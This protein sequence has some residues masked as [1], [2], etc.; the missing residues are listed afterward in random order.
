MDA[1]GRTVKSMDPEKQSDVMSEETAGELTEAMKDV[2]NE[3][4]G[5]A[6][7]LSGWTWPARPAPPRSPTW[8]VVTACRTRAWFV[9]FAPADDP[10]IAVAATVRSPTARA[11][12]SPP[13]LLQGVMET[14]L[15]E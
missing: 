9:G 6:A 8:T 10:Q 5:T 15:G 7:A 1:D 2:V 12:R 14:L 11:G 13:R 4:T 3:G